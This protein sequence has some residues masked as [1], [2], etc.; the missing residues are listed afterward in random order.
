MTFEINRSGFPNGPVERYEFDVPLHETQGPSWST[1]TLVQVGPKFFQSVPRCRAVHPDHDC[2]CT[3]QMGHRGGWDSNHHC[4]HD[5]SW[6]AWRRGKR[7]LVQV[8]DKR[9]LIARGKVY[10]D[11]STVEIQIEPAYVMDHD[12]QS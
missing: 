5:Q 2:Q 3:G 11:V 4:W 1:D 7:D 6:P 10:I 9:T 12:D 8:T